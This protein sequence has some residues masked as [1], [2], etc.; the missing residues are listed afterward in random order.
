MTLQVQIG[1]PHPIFLNPNENESRKYKTT[2]CVKSA[3]RYVNNKFFLFLSLEGVTHCVWGYG[4]L[5]MRGVSEVKTLPSFSCRL[6]SVG[7]S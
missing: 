4:H 1:R 3:T 6:S 2:T 5:G 7:D